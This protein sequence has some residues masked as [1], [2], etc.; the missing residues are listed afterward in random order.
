MFAEEG[1]SLGLVIRWVE[2]KSSKIIGKFSVDWKREKVVVGSIVIQWRSNER[3]EKKGKKRVRKVRV[4][5][6][7]KKKKRKGEKR[8]KVLVVV[9]LVVLKEKKR[10]R[11]LFLFRKY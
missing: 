3:K 11:P 8:E 6:K 10:K 7:K 1:E 2:V 4:G 9:V 5:C